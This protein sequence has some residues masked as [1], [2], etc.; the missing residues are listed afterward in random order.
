M[1]SSCLF[2]WFWTTIYKS[3]SMQNYVPQTLGKDNIVKI[4]VN[5]IKKISYLFPTA[6]DRPARPVYKKR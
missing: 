4:T 2:G 5:F 1:D 3:L 6:F